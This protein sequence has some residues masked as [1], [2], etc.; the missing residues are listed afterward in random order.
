MT[1]FWAIVKE[2]INK[3]DLLLEILDARFVEETRNIEL[4]DRIREAGKEFIFVI[5]KCDLVSQNYLNKEKQRL[6]KIAPCVFVSSI[7][8]LGTKMLRDEINNHIRGD[9]IKVGVVGYPNVGKSSVINVLKGRH[10]APTSSYSGY[11]KGLRDVNVT[12]KI[13]MVDTPG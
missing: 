9:R 2:V 6:S 7:M 11:T 10:S 12:S 1:N 3:S 4:E 8:R 13:T 5:N